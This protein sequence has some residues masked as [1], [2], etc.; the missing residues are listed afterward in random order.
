MD[1][2]VN[3]AMEG[4]FENVRQRD[5]AAAAGVALGTLYKA[6]RS[7]EDILMAAVA[8]QVE[9]LVQR[10]ISKPIQ[11]DTAVD[12]MGNLFEFLTRAMCRKPHYARSVIKAMASGEPE[13]T[14]NLA[15]YRD[16]INLLCVAALRGV[17]KLDDD[18]PP[19]TT[20][21]MKCA[22]FL[23]DIWFAA[24]VGWAAGLH[25]QPQVLQHM[26]EAAAVMLKGLDLQS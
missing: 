18:S 6:F 10:S 11:G 1:V 9:S 12:R 25:N 13:V 16:H 22:V 17:G 2:A 7:K 8:R 3:L 4:G 26:R 21:E 23:Q 24:L 14:A 5:V 19:P 20:G 15:S